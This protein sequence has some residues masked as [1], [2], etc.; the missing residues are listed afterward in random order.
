MKG[1]KWRGDCKS[2][3]RRI[4]LEKRQYERRDTERNEQEVV[5][6]EGRLQ[7]K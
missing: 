5:V 6:K 3:K 4:E 1:K 7:L 2:G